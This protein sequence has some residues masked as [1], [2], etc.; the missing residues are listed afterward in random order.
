[1]LP[2]TLFPMLLS[3]LLLAAPHSKAQSAKPANPAPSG[4]DAVLKASDITPK[5]FPE[6]VF[7]RGQ[8]AP[9]E[10]RNTGG[11]HF[12]D[13]FYVLAGIVDNSGYSTGV[14]EKYQ[15]YLLTEVPLEV[16]GQQLKPGAYGFGFL[17]GGQFLV[18]DVGGHDLFQIAS[19]RDKDLRRP[20]PLMVTTGPNSSAYRLYCG[21]D[22]VEFRRAQ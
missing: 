10:F 16:G 12:A 22:F 8:I 21:R 15:A 11:V 19:Q 3:L 13:G 9:V 4:K 20:T 6:R 14:R 18:M 17:T 7:F 1:M 2:R 5:I